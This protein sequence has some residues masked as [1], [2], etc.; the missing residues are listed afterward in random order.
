MQHHF[1]QLIVSVI[2]P[3]HFLISSPFSVLWGWFLIAKV[4]QFCRDASPLQ[5]TILITKL[6][7][8]LNLQLYRL[9]VS[10][11]QSC[12][13][14][15]ECLYVDISP[16]FRAEFLPLGCVLTTMRPQF[17]RDLFVLLCH[18]K[19]SHYNRCIMAVN[20]SS[21]RKLPLPVKCNFHKFFH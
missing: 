2:K 5:C 10:F 18:T 17:S 19:V 6:L 4:Y 21:S 1:S 8:A 3:W 7:H 13:C 9:G 15:V 20:V 12:V 16:F 11:L 14:I